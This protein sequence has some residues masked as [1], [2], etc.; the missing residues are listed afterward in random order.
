MTVITV[1]RITAQFTVGS[2][3]NNTPVLHSALADLV[4]HLTAKGGRCYENESKVVAVR[5]GYLSIL[6]PDSATEVLQC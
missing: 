1:Q 5:C 2:T 3:K 6:R 4:L